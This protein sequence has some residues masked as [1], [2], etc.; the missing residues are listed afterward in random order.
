MTDGNGNK[1]LQSEYV[2]LVGIIEHEPK[3]L[4]CLNYTKISYQQTSM[5]QVGTTKNFT[6]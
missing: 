4:P 6:S 2:K 1:Q 5:L 3:Q